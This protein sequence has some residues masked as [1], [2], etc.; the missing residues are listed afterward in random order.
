LARARQERGFEA[1]GLKLMGE[2]YAHEAA[3]GEE[4]EGQE[5]RIEQGP[6]EQAAGAYRQALALA[7]ELH[8]RPLLAHCHQG[9]GRLYRRRRDH[10]RAQE[11]MTI[12][13]MMYREMDMRLWLEGM[14]VEMGAQV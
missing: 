5:P 12:A 14:E 9:L 8:M 4:A 10:Q 3:K 2:V 6:F 1:W 7:A 11:H 13:T